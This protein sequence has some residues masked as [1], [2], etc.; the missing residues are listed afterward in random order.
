[1][2][3]KA[4]I[5]SEEAVHILSGSVP[6]DDF[7]Q[8]LV[9]HLGITQW[10]SHGGGNLYV[11]DLNIAV[12]KAL[13]TFVGNGAMFVL[14]DVDPQLEPMISQVVSQVPH[15]V[16]RRRQALTE[17]NLDALVSVYL[18][19]DPL[20]AGLS[21]IERDNAEAQAD[22]I[23]NEPC[24]SAEDLAIL[25]GSDASN[26]SALATRL[27]TRGAIFGVKRLGKDRYPKFQFRDGQ[28]RKIIGKIL[29]ALPADMTP[30]QTAFWFVRPNGWLDGARPVDRL[31]DEAAV[32]QAAAREGDDWIG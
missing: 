9:H 13:R 27:K 14:H 5:K 11:D 3:L 2:P 10:A 26:R 7:A 20:A 24:Y 21:E 16:E 19:H 30:W 31:D 18:S 25:V 4:A 28:P 1:M 8:L 23:E 32:L 17:Q 15:A 12:R 29:K 22:F 6:T